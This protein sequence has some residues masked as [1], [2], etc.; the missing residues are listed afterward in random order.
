MNAKFCD[1]GS[2]LM[3]M[4]SNSLIAVYD[5]EHFQEIRSFEIPNVVAAILSPCG[6]Y[7]LTFQKPSAPQDK[8]VSLWN[9]QSGNSVYQHSQKNIT[10]T[11]WYVIMDG[12]HNNN[13]HTFIL[14]SWELSDLVLHFMHGWHFHDGLCFVYNFGFTSGPRFSLAL[15]KLLRA[16][17]QRMRFN[18][19]TRG[20]SLKELYID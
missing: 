18:F 1:D 20:I 11:T 7:L 9:I 4:K 3:V 14:I 6:T 8:N 17:W 13:V 16:G 10:K 5:C 2:T 12:Y 19:S 15:T